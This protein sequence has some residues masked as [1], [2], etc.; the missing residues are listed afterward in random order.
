MVVNSGNIAVDAGY[1]TG[2]E[3]QSLGDISVANS[4]NID[5]GSGLNQ[6]D[7]GYGYTLYYGTQLA[8]GIAASSGG[9]G[10]AVQVVNSAD[11]TANGTFGAFGI[12]AV[13]SGIGG[14]VTVVNSGDILASQGQQVRRG[15]L[16]C[17]C[18]RR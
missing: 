7:M 15:R 4:G 1:A 3:V 10:A 17:I 16:R 14:T 13:S 6:Y 9:E 2:I 12:S 18:V 8:T 5:A 11:I